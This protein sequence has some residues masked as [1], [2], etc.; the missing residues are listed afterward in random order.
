MILQPA[1]LLRQELYCTASFGRAEGLGN[2]LLP[3]A[4]CLV[5]AQVN[6]ARMLAPHW[7]RLNHRP[8]LRG[9][10]DPKSYLSQIALAGL[11]VPGSA[12]VSGP[13]RL[14]GEHTYHKIAEPE[15]F[16]V[17]FDLR[18]TGRQPLIEFRGVKDN[19]ARLYPWKKLI[20]RDLRAITR[21][22]WLKV[23]DTYPQPLIAINVRRARDF[24]EPGPESMRSP[25][26][27][28]RTPVS[29]YVDSLRRIRERIG[30]PVPALVV[31]DGTEQDLRGLLGLDNVRLVHPRSAI[32]DLLIL[33]RARV[34]LAAGGSTFSAWASFLGGMPTISF[35]GQSLQWFGLVSNGDQYVGEFWPEAPNE[36]FLMQAAEAILQRCA[37]QDAM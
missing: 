36:H 9:G 27:P 37:G 31:S 29:W 6:H 12:S 19:F 17:V 13:M 32:S 26:G 33:S 4:R 1:P 30:F 18:D 15:A 16:D 28:V 10:L 2:R 25:T 11:F 34:L 24:P 3:W 21:G 14:W 7:L 23:A 8:L 22:A 35:P 20:Y 5:F